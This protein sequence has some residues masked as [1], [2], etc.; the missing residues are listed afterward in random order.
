NDLERLAATIESDDAPTWIVLTATPSS[1]PGYGFSG[2][3]DLLDDRYAEVTELCGRP[4]YL[5]RG[6]ARDTP[7]DPCGTG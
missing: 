6:A 5:L 3:T 7:V 4:L 1:W 2:P